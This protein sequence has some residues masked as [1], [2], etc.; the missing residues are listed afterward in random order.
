M[1]WL[2][3][4]IN[5]ISGA[6]D[7]SRSVDEQ[8][9]IAGRTPDRLGFYNKMPDGGIGPEAQ[10]QAEKRVARYNEQQRQNARDVLR[11]YGMALQSHRPGGAAALQ[12]GVGQGLA[13]VHMASQIGAPDNLYNTREDK[14]K[15]ARK[16][17][18]N[19]AIIQGAVSLG[20]AALGGALGGGAGA[21]LPLANTAASSIAGG[22]GKGGG[23]YL[24][25]GDNPG[26]GT[27]AP[28]GPTTMNASLGGSPAASGPGGMPTPSG[29][30]GS[31]T[32]SAPQPGSPGQDG[33][34]GPMAMGGGVDPGFGSVAMA[35]QVQ[36]VVSQISMQTGIPPWS[37]LH[38]V[39]QADP[40]ITDHGI[41]DAQIASLRSLMENFG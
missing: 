33:G 25:P 6:R 13:N 18:Q 7:R 1:S 23:Q 30:G 36:G 8:W 16:A 34:S 3:K 41:I 37:V 38:M 11:S 20:S 29:G 15:E 40:Q 31:G 5:K 4:Q 27:G 9:N 17:Q 28:S 14:L 10:Y 24:N 19:A 21:T 32:A 22:P 35:D 2:S 39:A 26:P 12:M